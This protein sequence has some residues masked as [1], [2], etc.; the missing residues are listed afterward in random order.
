M[1]GPPGSLSLSGDNVPVPAGPWPAPSQSQP[2]WSLTS[3]GVPFFGGRPAC[4]MRYANIIANQF[5]RDG[6]NE[7]TQQWAVYIASRETGCLPKTV[8]VNEQTRDDSHCAFQLNVLSGTFAPTG[9]LGRH[10]W[11]PAKVRKSM[12]DCADA[13]SDLW[14]SCGRGPW[15]PPYS[16]RPPTIGA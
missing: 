6:A 15:S 2:Q 13:A 7:A 4:S 10:G 1:F 8:T 9:E 16:C 11:T 3:D 14:V 12:R 5:A